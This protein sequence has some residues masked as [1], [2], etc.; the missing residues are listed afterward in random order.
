MRILSYPLIGLVHAYQFLVSP[1]L[2]MSC[3]YDPSCSHYACEALGRHGPLYGAW[4]AL[5]RVGRCHP[6]GGD[7]YDPVPERL[8][9]ANLWGLRRT[10]TLGRG[11]AAP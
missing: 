10:R 1:V 11:A 3:R 8:T 7:G 4:L 5:L 6:W 9:A 2:P